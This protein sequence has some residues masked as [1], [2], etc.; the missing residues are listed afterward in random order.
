M[1]E[2]G[3]STHDEI[4]SEVESVQGLDLESNSDS[5]DDEGFINSV[6]K[7]ADI[8]KQQKLEEEFDET[9][10]NEETTS[11][12]NNTGKDQNGDDDHSPI[13]K[14]N[15]EEIEEEEDKEEEKEEEEETEEEEHSKDE[16]NENDSGEENHEEPLDQKSEEKSLDIS[17]NHIEKD[18]QKKLKN[19]FLIV[20]KRILS[21]SL[22]N[23]PRPLL[24][25]FLHRFLQETKK[26]QA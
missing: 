22:Q 19:T 23:Q 12:V 5:S 2:K 14:E 20:P 16:E 13:E 18:P 7:A 10:K 1:S 4:F 8:Q 26:M 15:G 24:E 17:S 3:E 9:R 11:I 21:W 6:K 25:L